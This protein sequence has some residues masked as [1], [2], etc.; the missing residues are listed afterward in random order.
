MLETC[1]QHQKRSVCNIYLVL[2]RLKIAFFDNNISNT[3]NTYDPNIV[4]T[5][6][7]T[8]LFRL[9]LVTK[10][11]EVYLQMRETLKPRN[12]ILPFDNETHFE[13]KCIFQSDSSV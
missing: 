6:R 11:V 9:P 8:N 10:A 12:E 13:S 4:E 3:Y 2:L 5:W 1:I 7:L